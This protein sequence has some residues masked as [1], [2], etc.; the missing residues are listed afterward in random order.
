MTASPAGRQRRRAGRGPAPP[1]P[2]R[3][4]ARAVGRC[5]R[6]AGRPLATVLFAAGLAAHFALPRALAGA[7]RSSWPATRPA[8]GSRAWPGCG[9]CAAETLDVDLLMVVA[10]IG[11]AAVGQVLDGGLLIVI[12]ATSG[13]LEAVA[14]HRT[15]QAVRGLLDLAPDR[16]AR[17]DAARRPRRRW[18]RRRLRDRRR[19]PGPAGRAD[20]RRRPGAVRRQRRRPGHHHRRA[21]AG[22][23][24]RPGDEVFA[25]TAERHRRAAG[26]GRAGPPP[27]PW[28]PGSWRW[29]RRH[30]RP[31]PAPSCSS[32]RSSSATRIGMVTATVLLFAVPLL[33]GAAFQP[34]AA[35]R[36]DL[37][38][39][40]LAVRG[41]AGHDAAAA[42]RDGQR[43][44]ARRA[45][46]VR[47]RDGAARRAPR[48]SP[49]TRPAP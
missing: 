47:R 33:A 24:E 38:D 13:A 12:F 37:H 39:R 26:P 11:A 46:Q 49:S 25:G 22:R 17:L 44:T 3:G 10:A 45:G 7:G 4:R 23:Q 2:L 14:T 35:A 32:R 20:R 18:T 31:R 43:R 30:R 29:S 48:V 9:R 8:A 34:S 28:S 19:H 42:G 36:D 15:A 21:A 1:R 41:G 16:A 5:P 27:T 40:R 6:C